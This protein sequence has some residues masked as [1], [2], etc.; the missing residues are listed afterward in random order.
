[1]SI[2]GKLWGVELFSFSFGHCLTFL[3]AVCDQKHD[4]F[5]P[6]LKLLFSVS[7]NIKESDPAMEELQV[8]RSRIILVWVLQK[9]SLCFSTQIAA[10]SFSKL[11]PENILKRSTWFQEEIR[12]S[13]YGEAFACVI[14]TWQQNG[15][16]MLNIDMSSFIFST[17][18][19][20]R[21][22]NELCVRA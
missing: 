10:N 4:F 11:L 22:R 18:K 7:L 16:K 13:A 21:R 19:L 6:K 1:M 9:N 17:I 20:F 8:Q 2:P 5:G 14:K 12:T 3:V 15:G